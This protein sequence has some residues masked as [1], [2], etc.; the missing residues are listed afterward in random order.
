[1]YKITPNNDNVIVE[2]TNPET[3]SSGGIVMPNDVVEEA[4]LA[5]VLVPASD[6]YFRNG[7]LRDSPVYKAGDVVRL[8]KG[9]CGTQMP[10]SPKGKEW[11]CVPEDAIYYKVEEI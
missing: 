8:P 6:S 9:K 10:E 7:E 4:T 2:M 1:M 11:R 5:T 3:V